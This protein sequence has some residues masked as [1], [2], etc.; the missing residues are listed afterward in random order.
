MNE[1]RRQQGKPPK[2]A[3]AIRAALDAVRH[4]NGPPPAA[5]PQ[6]GGMQPDDRLTI[7]SFYDREVALRFLERLVAAGV[8][9]A[10]L[11]R[12]F[13]QDQVLVDCGDRQRAAEALA[14]HLAR[15]PDRMISRYRRSIDFLLL[16]AVLGG[17]LGSI[18]IASETMS[19]KTLQS[20]RGLLTAVG[21]TLYGA[22][23]GLFFGNI[24]DHSRR[25]GR[26]QFSV[27]DILFAMTL[28]SLLFLSWRALG[29]VWR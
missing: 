9:S 20:P 21:F 28:L 10:T 4:G 18:G 12:G 19:G 8:M 14:E 29:I 17:T 5:G 26:L 23:L 13:R 16:G 15:T 25:A 24:D 6:T 2:S 22:L 7:A 3:S 11:R 27:R 1:S